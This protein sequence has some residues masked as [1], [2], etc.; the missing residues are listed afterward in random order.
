ME[1]LIRLKGKAFVWMSAQKHL[2]L[3][4]TKLGAVNIQNIQHL[5]KQAADFRMWVSDLFSN[6][7][8]PDSLLLGLL[9]L[10]VPPQHSH[11]RPLLLLR[12]VAQVDH[13]SRSAQQAG[14]ETLGSS[15]QQPA[16]SVTVRQVGETTWR[17]HIPPFLYFTNLLLSG[18]GEV[19]IE[20]IPTIASKYSFGFFKIIHDNLVFKWTAFKLLVYKTFLS[21]DPWYMSH[22][23]LGVQEPKFVRLIHSEGPKFDLFCLLQLLGLD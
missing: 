15:Q 10:G 2:C 3:C 9:Q 16:D 20:E 11:Y 1:F 5:W 18:G 19:P 17:C 14:V 13:G 6:R 12:Q 21:H 4:K 23:L 22:V 8:L 7:F